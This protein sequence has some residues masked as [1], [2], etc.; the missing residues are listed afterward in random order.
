MKLTYIILHLEPLVC[1]SSQVQPAR[2]QQSV[3]ALIM[4]C[5]CNKRGCSIDSDQRKSLRSNER[6][7]SKNITW[8]LSNAFRS[9]LSSN[10]SINSQNM[11]EEDEELNKVD[12]K[13]GSF[14]FF[15]DWVRFEKMHTEAEERLCLN[16]KKPVTR[17]KST[18]IWDENLSWAPTWILSKKS[19]GGNSI[20][21]AKRKRIN[22][23]MP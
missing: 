1:V 2:I 11:Q 8:N 10:L 3:W 6:S 20:F 22:T 17:R 5:F 9:E 18:S 15:F 21:F 19:S 7:R 4:S 13:V 16:I 12:D 14:F 23:F